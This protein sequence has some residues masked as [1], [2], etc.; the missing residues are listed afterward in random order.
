MS[1]RQSERKTREQTQRI[2]RML[3]FLAWLEQASRE[4]REH[5]LRNALDDDGR[6]TS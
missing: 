5:V 1:A 3:E 4:E 2:K 6:E